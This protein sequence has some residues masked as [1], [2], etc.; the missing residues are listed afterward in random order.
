MSR[1]GRRDGKPWSAGEVAQLIALRDADKPWREVAAKMPGRTRVQ[2]QSRYHYEKR[3][4]GHHSVRRMP[5]GALQPAA[6]PARYRDL[7]SL[8]LGDPPIGRSALDRQHIASPAR[9]V[10]LGRLT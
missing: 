7:S 2:C 1:G 6:P 10:S 9:A 3:A 8:L 4:Q 5:S